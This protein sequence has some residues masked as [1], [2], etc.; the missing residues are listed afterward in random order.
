MNEGFYQSAQYSGQKTLNLVEKSRT[1][2]GTCKT[3]RDGKS[4]GVK[5]E[6]GM[7][8]YDGG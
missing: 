6:N 5:G 1:L 8:N 3:I 4:A 7:N 2:Y